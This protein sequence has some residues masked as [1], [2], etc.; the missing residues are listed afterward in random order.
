[1]PQRRIQVEIAGHNTAAPA[2]TQL[3]QGLQR[4]GQVADQS[5]AKLNRMGQAA[6]GL[7]GALSSLAS[8]TIAFAGGL[9]LQQALL[10]TLE[11]ARQIAIGF[12]STMEQSQ[13]AWSTLLKNEQLANAYLY[14]LQQT[15]L[16]LGIS[17]EEMNMGTR[18]LV[19]MGVAASKVKELYLDIKAVAAGTGRADAG[20]RLTYAIGQMLAK[21]KVSAEEMTQQMGELIPAWQILADYIHK[22]VAETQAMAE[23]GQILP[24]TFVEAFQAFSKAEYGT[25]L[26]KQAKTWE[27]ALSRMGTAMQ[28]M[29]STAFEPFFRRLRDLANNIADFVSS[30]QF[31]DWAVGVAAR[32]DIALDAF[33]ALA[34]GIADAMGAIWTVVN[35]A[36]MAIY[37][38][39][40]WL[41]PFAT[42][43][44]SLVSQVAKGTEAIVASYD[45]MS[46]K[47]TT[48]LNNTGASVESFK[49][50]AEELQDAAQ[51]QKKVFD[52]LRDSLNR[53]QESL[54][55][56]SQTPIKG[57]DEYRKKLRAVEYEITRVQLALNKA[58][59][60][61]ASHRLV[62]ALEKQL[63]VLQTKA[64]DIRLEE[65]LKLGPLR[66]KIEDLNRTAEQPFEKIVK[67]IKD[68]QTEIT[69]LTPKVAEAE[70]K[71]EGLQR[72]YEDAAEAAR[73][74]G[75][76]TTTAVSGVSSLA[77]RTK[78]L[79]DKLADADK[80][81]KEFQDKVTRTREDVVKAWEPY[82]KMIEDN[83][84]TPLRKIKETGITVTPDDVGK[85]LGGMA[86]QVGAWI[87]TNGPALEAQFARLV[88]M[89]TGWLKDFWFGKDDTS[90]GGA[91]KNVDQLVADMVKA[92]EDKGPEA[93]S[94]MGG[95]VGQFAA[96]ALL[97]GGAFVKGL[98][99]FLTGE[100]GKDA[101]KIGADLAGQFAKG[102]Q[103]GITAGLKGITIPFG[104][105]DLALDKFM[106]NL[107]DYMGAKIN[108]FDL[109]GK[110]MKRTMPIAGSVVTDAAGLPMDDQPAVSFGPNT[111][112]TRDQIVDDFDIVKRAGEDLD[113]SLKKSYDKVTGN[114][115]AMSVGVTQSVDDI[116]DEVNMLMRRNTTDSTQV[117]SVW[118][119]LQLDAETTF[120]AVVE[121]VD[122]AIRKL[123]D[124]AG[125]VRNTPSVTLVPP[126]VPVTQSGSRNPADVAAGLGG[127]ASGGRVRAGY[128]YMVGEDGPE[129]FFPD[130]PGV[131]LPNGSLDGGGVTIVYQQS[132][133][134]I[135]EARLNERVDL[136]YLLK[137]SAQYMDR[138]LRNFIRQWGRA[139]LGMTS[140]M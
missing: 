49:A 92:I 133:P 108:L 13:I 11:K 117:M 58:K 136:D 132:G 41:N 101:Q 17:F 20:D 35:Q 78:G 70:A 91:R 19:N 124:W 44:P 125:T 66:D 105:Y 50:K 116:A 106:E 104:P 40:S 85:W 12:N 8:Q 48:S 129:P 68:S 98:G 134:L 2:V 55:D 46:K 65:K 90:G 84:L 39:L 37:E 33:G 53:A 121:A 89:S 9:M 138:D 24:E 109:L 119:R 118:D 137:R 126:S 80:A 3:Q 4:T 93:A 115:D 75:K 57:T 1:M 88:S 22:S 32:L 56:W 38:A 71:Y 110:S 83:V 63:D 72:A 86:G 135:G 112:K 131:I 21:G 10:T 140:R 130:L 99:E 18:V 62:A 29:G 14:D 5:S 111:V 6:N 94:T 27:G 95:W 15:A 69:K 74:M 52:D 28:L 97:A 114:A 25:M 127:R 100:G 42:H 64:E 81:L 31:Q 26:A 16:K 43:S 54:R 51:A 113:A 77:D 59:R 73:D 107:P 128:G 34:R 67:G 96:G 82:K 45:D 61:G 30:D 87:D 36:G 23:A 122:K 102:F 7:R 103:E 60:E 79:A 47:V 120:G 76:A 123:G 139:P